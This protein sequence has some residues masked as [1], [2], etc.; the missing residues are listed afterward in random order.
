MAHTRTVWPEMRRMRVGYVLLYALIGPR[1]V[2]LA[3]FAHS[4]S[5]E[6]TMC[7]HFQMSRAFLQALFHDTEPLNN[8]EQFES[9]SSFWPQLNGTL[10]EGD[11]PSGMLVIP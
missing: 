9:T 8:H 2:K 3:A 1:V 10:R 6:Q 4:N 11:R 7:S 5:K